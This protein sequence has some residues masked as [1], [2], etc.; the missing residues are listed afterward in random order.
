M[1]TA[2]D[3]AFL[4]AAD[5]FQSQPDE[6]LK[7]VLAQGR[8]EEFGPG[9]MVFRQ[10]QQGDRLY[11][12]KSGVLEILASPEGGGGRCPSP[13]SARARCSASWRC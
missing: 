5:L 6:V 3:P 8:L 10:G 13:T 7:A 2:I 1:V 11:I 12:V 9:A 4:R